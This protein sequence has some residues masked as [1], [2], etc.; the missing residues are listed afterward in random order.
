VI[1]YLPKVKGCY[2]ENYPL[3]PITWFKVGGNAQILFKP[4][5]INDLRFFLAN[6]P[7]DIPVS[8]VG[9]CSNILVHDKGIR[10][11]VIK[12]GKEFAGIDIIS[13][14]KIKIGAASLNYNTA[15]FCLKNNIKGFEFLVGIPGT[16][17][18]GISMN[19][20]AYFK[21]F[22]DIIF[23]VEAVDRNGNIF[24]LN[25]EQMK[26]EY[27]NNGA[28]D[29][30]I[31]TSMTCIYSKGDPNLIRA[32]MDHISKSRAATQPIKEKTCGS[33]FANP[34]GHK[35]WKLIEEVG[36]K[37]FLLGGAQVSDMHANFIINK[38]NASAQ[39]I[40]NLIN[41]IQS[42]VLQEKNILLNL[43][44]RKMGWYE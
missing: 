18:G 4:Y 28:P 23:S 37:G 7:E 24:E 15:Q 29:G 43:E 21:E 22:K 44:I 19:A 11:V 42:T 10:G 13:D 16:A 27:R 32:S 38:N 3:S 40:E 25:N 33:T 35:A 39:D 8:V 5:D 2:R 12:L 34:T 9:A 36:M 41:A 14:T 30:L 1:K 31:F 6:T 26:F 20:G 17:G